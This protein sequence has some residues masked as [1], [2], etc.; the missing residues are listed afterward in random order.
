MNRISGGTIVAGVAGAPVSHSLS[1]L[2]Q[3]AWLAASDLDGVY[4]PFSPPVGGFTAFATGLAGGAVRGLNVT[5]PFKEEALRLASRPSRR[6]LRADAANLLLFEP[7]GE[8]HADN[9]DGEGLLGALAAQAPGFDPSAGPAVILGAGGAARGAAAALADAGAPEVRIV[10]RTPARALELAQSVGDPVR[11]AELNLA[12]FA[13]ARL[14]VNATSLGLGGM[15]GPAAPFRRTPHAVVM[16]MVYRPLRTEFLERAEK[17]GLVTVDG[18]EMLI[19]QAA[20][21]FTALF[22]RAPPPI[23]VRRLCLAEL[24]GSA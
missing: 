3:N 21:S 24:G 10:N 4:V 5:V 9:T 15:V 19:R 17:A 23:D 2:I 11:A 12:A 14:I 7:S 6:A 22:G 8:I 13:D 1:P 16:D 18:L 20:P